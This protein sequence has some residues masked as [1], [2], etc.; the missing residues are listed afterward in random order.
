MAVLRVGAVGLGGIS[1]GVHIPGIMKCPDLELVAICDIDPVRLKERAEQYGIAQDHCF[2]DYHDLIACPDVDV[3]DIAT[4]PHV[5]IE[6]AMAAAKA[7]KSYGVEKP[8]GTSTEAARELAKVTH[9]MGVK[10]MIYFSYRYKA[11]ARTLRDIIVS[12]KLGKVRHIMMQYNQSG[13]LNM[14]APL[15]WRMQKKYAGYGALGDLGC[16][17]LDLVSFVTGQQYVEVTT[18]CGIRK[19]E[20]PLKD[21]TGTGFVD[22]DEVT[23]V[24]ATMSDGADAIFHITKDSYGRANYQ[25]LEITGEKA[26][27]VYH[28]DRILNVD[29]LEITDE[30]TEPFAFKFADIPDEMRVDQMQEWANMLNG[31][32]DGLS[33]DIDAGVIN[34]RLMDGIVEAAEKRCWVTL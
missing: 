1:N 2:I 8:L 18:H 19:L 32:G 21:G 23:N 25:R 22:V 34:Q 16:H 28:L 15:V 4:P 6:I 9:E 24:L 33:A 10:S 27:L 3:V 26:T 12:G 11:A 13:W 29:E 17:A 20:R 14:E 5:H 31:C 7:G 30:T